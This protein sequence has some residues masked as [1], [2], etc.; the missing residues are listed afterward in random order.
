M[1]HRTDFCLQDWNIVVNCTVIERHSPMTFQVYGI[2]CFEI[3]TVDDNIYEFS[4]IMNVGHQVLAAENINWQITVEQDVFGVQF[5]MGLFE[6]KL[7]NVTFLKPL[8]SHNHVNFRL[9]FYFFSSILCTI[10]WASHIVMSLF[11]AEVTRVLYSTRMERLLLSFGIWPPCN[12]IPSGLL[13][14]YYSNFWIYYW[15]HHSTVR[16]IPCYLPTL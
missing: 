6:W 13:G 14:S 3:I 4:H 7:R 5:F 10:I 9:L 2:G 15:V 16:C 11:Y 8:L 1:S 12:M